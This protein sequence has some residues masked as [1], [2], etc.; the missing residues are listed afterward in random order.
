MLDKEEY[1]RLADF[2]LSFPEMDDFI[3]EHPDIQRLDILLNEYA[4][5]ASQ[6]YYYS[7]DLRISIQIAK[8]KF[9]EFVEQS[10]LGIH[11]INTTKCIDD[12]SI[13]CTFHNEAYGDKKP[14]YLFKK[15]DVQHYRTITEKIA[16]QKVDFSPLVEKYISHYHPYV[17]MEIASAFINAKQ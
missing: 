10:H 5:F 11:S 13:I 4:Q 1:Q 16:Y 3:E 2:I 9:S 7:D 17:N 12:A 6:Q 8:E 15:A 14:E